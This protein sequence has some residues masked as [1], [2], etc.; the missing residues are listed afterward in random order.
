[1]EVVFP[2][3]Q[4]DLKKRVIDEILAYTMADNVKA[5]ELMPDGS[6]R[7]VV[8]KEGETP[9]RSQSR[10]MEIADRKA[11]TPP[12]PEKVEGTKPPSVIRVRKKK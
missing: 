1:M 8:L 2:I 12:E 4:P 10:F 7:K 9:L 3:E 11:A 5:R 6:Y